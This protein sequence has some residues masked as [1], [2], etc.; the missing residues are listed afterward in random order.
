MRA[1]DVVICHVRH[2][3]TLL[4]I[5]KLNAFISCCV[6]FLDLAERTKH[7][8]ELFSMVKV[9][10]NTALAIKDPKKESLIPGVQVL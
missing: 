4:L 10:F 3:H 8:H 6:F 7:F 1:V 5:R 2:T 9:S